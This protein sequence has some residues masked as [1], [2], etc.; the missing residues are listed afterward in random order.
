[1]MVGLL[2]IL[3]AGG[4]YVPLDPDHPLERLQYILA[5][6][7]VSLMLTQAGLLGKLG[8]LAGSE[9]D[10]IALDRD[11][12]EIG[13]HPPGAGGNGAAAGPEHLAYVIYTSGST[14]KPKGVMIPH[15]A[16]TNLLTSMVTKQPGLRGADRLLAVTTYCFD[17]AGFELLGPLLVGACCDI[18]P[19]ATAGD[20][21]KLK[22]ALRERRPSIMQATPATWTMLFR[23]GWRNEEQVR[24]VC[25]GEALSETLRASLVAT[26]CEAWNMYGP[27]ET[28]IW[29]T[30]NE[31]HGRMVP[32]S[33]GRPIANT[34]VYI[35]DRE[36][37]P[38]AD[39][40]G[41]RA[42]HW[43]R[44]SGAGLSQQAGADGRALRR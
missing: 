11:W 24:I 27:T 13:S 7:G 1:M 22:R 8:G 19:S 25:G 26:D 42:V 5:D 41:G 30:V 9:L 16:L 43:R 23:S 37:P 35:V 18:C 31:D 17:I 10:I 21:E 15:R 4:A 3:K 39:R 12:K 32:V 28:T 36:L 34:A 14:G 38:G 29:S 44:R 20:V 33:I 2:G 6:S 40:G